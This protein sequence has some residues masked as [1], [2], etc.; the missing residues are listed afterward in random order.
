MEGLRSRSGPSNHSSTESSTQ[1]AQ[2][3]LQD[4]DRVANAHG[5]LSRQT[6]P[7]SE[8]DGGRRAATGNGGGQQAQP[9]P[10][11]PNESE[12]VAN[13]CTT[14]PQLAE[15]RIW[16]QR[17]R[18]KEELR[19]LLE[20]RARYEAGDLTAVRTVSSSSKDPTAPP[21]T[22]TIALPRP[23]PLHVFAKRNRAEYNCWERD[24]E[25][26]FLRSP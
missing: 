7:T 21:A 19:S 12:S 2:V 20:L 4:E 6:T 15:M 24:C 10:I 25:G 26:F 9:E 5:T 1:Q 8:T 3:P 13:S 22:P 18:E 16:L 17:T 11:Q 23:E 14:N